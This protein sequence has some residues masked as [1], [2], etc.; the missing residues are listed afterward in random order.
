MR[1]AHFRLAI[2]SSNGYCVLDTEHRIKKKEMGEEGRVM[3]R[4]YFTGSRQAQGIVYIHDTGC[5]VKVNDIQKLKIKLQRTADLW[6][7]DCV[8]MYN[9][10]FQ[11]RQGRVR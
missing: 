11:N 4:D 9:T 10:Q 1:I 8:Q 7:A 3:L 6:P 5:W 2:I